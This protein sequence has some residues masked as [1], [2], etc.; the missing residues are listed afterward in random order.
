[1]SAVSDLVEAEP[2]ENAIEV[3]ES[4]LRKVSPAILL[5]RFKQRLNTLNRKTYMDG[6]RSLL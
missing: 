1:M 6:P 4:A 2:Y 3:E 5:A